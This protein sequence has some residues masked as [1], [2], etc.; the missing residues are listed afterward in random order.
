MNNKTPYFDA[1]ASTEMNI[2]FDTLPKNIQETIIQSHGN[3]GSLEELKSIANNL[4]AK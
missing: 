1:A 3:V 2:Y 4:M